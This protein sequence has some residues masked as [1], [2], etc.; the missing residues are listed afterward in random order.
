MPANNSPI[1]VLT[2]NL[3]FARLSAA[4]TASDGSGTLVTAFTAGTNGSRIDFITI[5]NS[6]VTAATSSNMV[7]K[8]FITDTLG[9]NPRMLTE[10]TLPAVTRS[11]T[12]AGSTT[13]VTFSNGLIIPSGT[14]IRV[15]QSVYS[16]A[17]DQNDIIVR[18][19]D[20]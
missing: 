18:G 7:I 17:Q 11:T 16:G 9:V 15:C 3:G 19:G 20:Y 14:L 5:T 2:P 8:I 13:T 4:N 12:V 1:F 6:Q 10:V